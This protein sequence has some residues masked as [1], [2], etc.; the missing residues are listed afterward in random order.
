MRGLYYTGDSVSTLTSSNTMIS[1]T[2]TLLPFL[3]ESDRL[4]DNI[5]ALQ[6]FSWLELAPACSFLAHYCVIARF[7][8]RHVYPPSRRASK[9][10]GGCKCRIF[11]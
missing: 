6:G 11:Y 4:L 1:G 5:W 8:P 7:R 3:G 10:S 9:L 2:H